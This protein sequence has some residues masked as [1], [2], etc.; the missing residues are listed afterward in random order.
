MIDEALAYNNMNWG[1]AT[2]APTAAGAGGGGGRRGGNAQ[3]VA[4]YKWLEPRHMTNISDRW[5]RDKN[6]DL[7]Y[8]FF[9]GVGMETWENI[10]GIWNEMTPH[11]SEVVRRTAKIERKFAGE[12]V[13]ADWEPHT[14][15]LQS[16]HLCQ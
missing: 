16:Q 9:N 4:K 8:A 14:P 15:V 1:Q 2:P 10:W 5:Q 11:D 13:S 12:L 6:I 3:L 7:Q